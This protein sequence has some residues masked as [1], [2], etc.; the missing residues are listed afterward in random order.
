MLQ[1]I[2][3]ACGNDDDSDGGGFLRGIVEVDETYIGGKEMN[4]HESKKLKAGRGTVGKMAVIGMLQRGG[5]VKAP[6]LINTEARAIQ[7]AVRNV[8]GGGAI[9]CAD[10][11]ASYRGMP[12]YVHMA[13]SRS[14][15]QYVDG[16]AYTKG[17]ESVWALL[18]RG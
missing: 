14:A 12:E 16:M 10:E 1:R 18:K 15:K 11:H 4:K 5:A 17:I 2:R 9:L 13:V 3:E 8:V 6:V 7:S